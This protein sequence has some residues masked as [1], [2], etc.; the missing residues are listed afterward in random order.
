MLLVGGG[1]RQEQRCSGTGQAGCAQP[2]IAVLEAQPDLR[3]ALPLPSA[4][5]QLSLRSFPALGFYGYNQIITFIK[6]EITF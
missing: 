4:S 3:A 1:W 5:P 2:V 6:F